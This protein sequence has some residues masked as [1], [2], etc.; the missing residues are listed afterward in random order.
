LVIGQVKPFYSLPGS[1]RYQPLPLILT[2]YQNL[3]GNADPEPL[4][5]I[6]YQFRLH[7]LHPSV[8]SVTE[9]VAELPSVIK[10]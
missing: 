8:T 6:L 3:P 7:F 10:L 1:S 5:L 2:R 9:S 4:P